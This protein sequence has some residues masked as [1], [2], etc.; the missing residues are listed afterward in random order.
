[1]LASRQHE[2]IVG[3]AFRRRANI[4]A[5]IA[6]LP[7]PNSL[8]EPLRTSI[9][10]EKP[11]IASLLKTCSRFRDL[12][13]FYAGMV[14]NNTHQDSFLVNQ[15]ITAS[16][17]FFR[18]DFALL[19]FRQMKNPNI[20][21]YNAL[22]RGFIR[23]STPI[24]ALSFYL[25]NMPTSCVLPTS[26]TFSSLIKACALVPA[27]EFGEALHGRILKTGFG[28][29]VFVQTGMIDFYTSCNRVAESQKVF[30]EMT[31]RD[32]VAWATMISAYVQFGDLS[33]A[34]TL[35]REMP[36]RDIVSWN[37]MI[38]GYS[39]SR[40]VDTA[41]ALFNQM[42]SKDLVSWTTM[43]SCYS[44]NKKFREAIETFKRMKTAKV[45]PD[46]VTI[47]TVIS[48]CAHL[49]AL[50]FGK[51]VHLYAAQNGFHLDVYIGSALIDMYAKCG[52][53]ERSL[54]VFFKL[55][56][57]NLFCWNSMIEGLAVHGFAR[58]ALSIFTKM[59]KK[60]MKPNKVTFVSVLSACTHAGF[61]E[62]GRRI[63]S[64]MTQTHS[65]PAELEHYGCM[66]DLLSRAGLLEEAMNLIENM[67]IEPNSVIWG[68]LLGGCKTHRNMDIG[69][70]AAKKL[71]VLEPSNCGHYS[72]L[73]NLYADT[74]QWGEVAYIRSEMKYRSVLKSS[75]GHSWIELEHKVHEFVA[76]DISH[77]FFDQINQ[78]ILELDGQQKLSGCE[79][80]LGFNS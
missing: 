62:E 6:P 20:F 70:I 1:M 41:A 75:P 9:E 15:F 44:Q 38:A 76:S 55:Q 35:F 30:D 52:S 25:Q 17:T 49:G 31:D 29:N 65:I 56:E 13:L 78:L 61:V 4:T 12:K 2:C 46:E 58:D 7:S 14:K 48:A 28:S 64:S 77:P 21:V 16:S 18:I 54:L 66:V 51:E 43:I 73:V 37:T 24:Q 45:L 11:R 72:L 68:A 10:V 5:T 47:A 63:F 26:F 79:L 8:S 23:C 69:L 42:P 74:N 50:D 59:E 3:T 71:M 80:E 60:K 19:I 39:R 36:E 32:A 53:M 22:L 67:K 40:D 34:E 33:S 57:K 27:L